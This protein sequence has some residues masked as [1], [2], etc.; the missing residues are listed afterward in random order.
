MC[1]VEQRMLGV[2]WWFLERILPAKLIIGVLQQAEIPAHIGFIMDGNRRFART[3]E[4]P[5]L[6]GHLSGSTTLQ[7][8]L[9]WCYHLNVKE[10]SVYAFSVDNFKRPLEEVSYLM[11]L[12]EKKF[13]ELATDENSVVYR[14]QV[15]I[16]FWGDLRLVP[17]AVR[18]AC[19]DLEAVTAK[20]QG[21]RLNILFAYSSAYERKSMCSF[22]Q[23]SLPLELIIR[24]SGET[25]LSDFMLNQ[26]SGKTTIVFVDEFWPQ[27]SLLSFGLAIMKAKFFSRSFS[28]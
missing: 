10:V 6:S 2:L 28:L 24:T 18:K 20:F 22:S 26:I 12:A 21:P 9:D 5:V 13:T 8:V 14:R 3:S 4:K 7:H 1:C 19:E 17:E 23:D 25:R 16:K 15:R 27:L 11:N